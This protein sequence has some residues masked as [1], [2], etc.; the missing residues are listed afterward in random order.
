MLP[1]F[2][3]TDPIEITPD[4]SVL[5]VN[6]LYIGT[7]VGAIFLF[8]IMNRVGRKTILL[9]AALPKM[10]SWILFA[11]A[12]SYTLICLARFSAGLSHGVTFTVLSIYQCEI[13]SEQIRGTAGAVMSDLINTSVLVIYVA[14]MWL[15]RFTTS[16]MALAIQV[17][18]FG[19]FLFC[20][21]SPYFLIRK[22]KQK[23]A[24][25]TLKWLLNRE[26][27]K[28]ELEGVERIVAKE[29]ALANSNL[30]TQ[31]RQVFS[32]RENR[33]AAVIAIILAT[34]LTWC[35]CAPIFAYQSYTFS[36]AGFDLSTNVSITLTGVSNIVGG[37]ACILS[38]SRLGKRPI[39]LI[40]MPVICFSLLIIAVFFS[41]MERSYD[42][43]KFNWIP[44][45]FIVVYIF[46]YGFSLYPL[47]Y[48]Y[49]GEIFPYEMKAP[50]AISFAIFFSVSSVCT[51]QIYQVSI[52]K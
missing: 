25:Q 10:L 3:K 16:M 52:N 8:F 50:A 36:A 4:R 6:S 28:K 5:V 12:N 7:G 24:E 20:R 38:I 22:N 15:P 26:D 34:A 19:T 23:A 47:V 2:G 37:F 13:T 49:M 1:K 42:V 43:K 44:T 46:A 45:V 48:T 29:D 39:L 40:A 30:L 35:G 18:F 14:A 9:G 21:E 51:V 27:V 17:I 33:R 41:F 31:I 32:K 11:A